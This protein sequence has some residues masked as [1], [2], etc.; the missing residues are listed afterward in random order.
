L[1]VEA[2]SKVRIGRKEV[3]DGIEMSA[4]IA[5]ELQFLISKRNQTC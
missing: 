5:K 3:S 2:V 1:I 4:L